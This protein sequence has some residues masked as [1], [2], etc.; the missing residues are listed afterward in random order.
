MFEALDRFE[1]RAD[2][3]MMF[4][5]TWTSD[6]DHNET[7]SRLLRQARDEYSVKLVPVQIQ[8]VAGEG[9]PWRVVGRVDEEGT[10]TATRSVDPTWGQS[11]TKLLAFNQT[12]YQRVL[13]LDSDASLYQHMDE[14]F[15]TPS[16]PVAMPQ[17]YWMDAADRALS[18]QVLLV[19]PSTFEFDRIQERMGRR[20][21]RRFDM[22]L[23]NDLYRDSA[24]VL[25]HRDYDLLT[26]EFRGKDHRKYLGND[27]EVWDPDRVLADARYVHFSDWPVSKPWLVTSPTTIE[28]K[29]PECQVWVAGAPENCRNRDIWHGLYT[30]FARRRANVCG[31]M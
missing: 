27:V 4:P 11:Y 7:S 1:S 25:P 19:E 21:V 8:T 30:D 15:D 22:D 16:A 23:L 26:G 31:A 24:L 20:K 29:Q 10:D 2:R 6:E 14:L 3:M 13:S 17:A 18:S 12:Q 5:N 9:K 28:D